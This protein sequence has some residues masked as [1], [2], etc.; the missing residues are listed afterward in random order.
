MHRGM[1]LLTILGLPNQC[2]KTRS[3]NRE[4][5]FVAP[6]LL[7]KLETILQTALVTGEEETTTHGGGVL[8]IEFVAVGDTVADHAGVFDGVG[9]GAG[10]DFADM[11]SKGAVEL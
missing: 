7:H 6:R 11:G 10:V 2:V 5:W 9:F 3:L 1:Q 8:L 4:S